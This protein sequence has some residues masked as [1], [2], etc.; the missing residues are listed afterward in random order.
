M[1]LKILN[2]DL[3]KKLL[4]MRSRKEILKKEI[5]VIDVESECLEKEILE[6][7]DSGYLSPEGFHVLPKIHSRRNVSWKSELI[8]L[9]GS[10]VADHIFE[11]TPVTYYRNLSITEISHDYRKWA[12]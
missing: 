2:P 5:E 9:L 4:A 12:S 7:L 11:A 1:N 3:L 8:N 10:S 6:S